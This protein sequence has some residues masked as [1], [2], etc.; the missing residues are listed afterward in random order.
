MVNFKV[1]F[2]TWLTVAVCEFDLLLANPEPR[3]FGRGRHPSSFIL[4]QD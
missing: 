4:L 2:C 1:V 3:G